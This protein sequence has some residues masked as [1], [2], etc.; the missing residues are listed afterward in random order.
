MTYASSALCSLQWT[1]IEN[2][3][4]KQ[5]FRFKYFSAFCHGINQSHVEHTHTACFDRE[6]CI[7]FQTADLANV[8]Y[9][10]L[11]V[12]KEPKRSSTTKTLSLEG[13]SLKVS[14]KSGDTRQLR[15]AVNSF[16]DL[17]ILVSRAIDEFTPVNFKFENVS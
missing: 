4:F 9:N 14:F 3:H 16:L 7:P 11:R 15:T 2:G 8:A 10:S 13:N 5:Y 12:D 1:K 6:L 17:L